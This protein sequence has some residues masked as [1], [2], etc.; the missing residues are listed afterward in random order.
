[1][2]GVYHGHLIL[3]STFLLNFCAVG[4]FGAA[5]LY[6]GPLSASFPDA[7]AGCLAL[8]CTVQIVVGMLASF[9]GGVAQ[10]VLD[11]RGLRL[12]WLFAGGGLL[13]LAGSFLAAASHTVGGV[14]VG[15]ALLGVGLGLGGFAAGGVCVLWYERSR[16]AML[17]LAMSGQGVGAIFYARATSALLEYYGEG[18]S[19]DP[20][21]PAMRWTGLFSFAVCA[22]AAV[23]MRM[24][25]D[26]EVETHE[27]AELIRNDHIVYG[28]YTADYSE[29]D[30][31]GEVSSPAPRP[32]GGRRR[33][34]RRRASAKAFEKIRVDMLNSSAARHGR[35]RRYTMLSSFQAVGSAPLLALED[36]RDIGISLDDSTHSDNDSLRERAGDKNGGGDSQLTLGQVSLS[37]TSLVINAF[38]LVACF[39]ILNMQVLLPSYVESLGLPPSLAAEALSMFGAG[40]LLGKFALGPGT[41]R[42][43]ARKTLAASFYALSALFGAWPACTTGT[44]ICALALLYGSLAGAISSLPL[45]VLADAYGERSP[46]HVL[47]LNGAANLFKV[48]GYLLG[49]PA[50][51][52]LAEMA[53]GYGLPALCSGIG[54]FVA[55]TL[56]LALPSP[57]EQQ[58]QLSSMSEKSSKSGLSPR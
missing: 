25:A 31:D 34:L 49:P 8:Y 19:D 21:K 12:G 18:G 46:E 37:R 5:G 10:D 58:E 57:R 38:M 28:S 44:S 43:G 55:S 23:P 26:D 42:I 36:L 15:S 24:P 16:G 41:D 9:W 50:A 30:S 20:W 11:R 22:A 1:M 29:T 14:L 56:L 52:A 33:D 2:R 3:L 4:S 39:Q 6:L 13:M 53:G 48:P 45:I 54:T 47:A 40:D 27:T 51:G 17:L 32:A 7:P 35:A